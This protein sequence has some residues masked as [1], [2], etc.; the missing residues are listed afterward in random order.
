[1]DPSLELLLSDIIIRVFPVMYMMGGTFVTHSYVLWSRQ[2]TT[3]SIV[4]F[5]AFLEG[6]MA[7]TILLIHDYDMTSS[8][9]KRFSM[10]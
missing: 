4:I 2:Q 3:L 9:R 5:V 7:G 1:M 8:P 6:G 10:F